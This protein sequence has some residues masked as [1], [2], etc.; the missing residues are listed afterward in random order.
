MFFNYNTYKLNQIEVHTIGCELNQND[1]LKFALSL[2]NT[3]PSIVFNTCSLLKERAIESQTLVNLISKAYP[4]KDLYVLGCDITNNPE[5]YKK[6]KNVYPSEKL[7]EYLSN[8]KLNDYSDEKIE[9]IKSLLHSSKIYNNENYFNFKIQNGCH[10][11]CSFCLI[12]RTRR[13]V[14]S[15]PYKDIKEQLSILLDNKDN[16]SLMS[17]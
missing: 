9:T 17:L 14:Y 8:N 11:N 10:M 1:A 12:N 6:Y 4:E 3:K 15:L 16:C 7:I 5:L 13:P 2:D